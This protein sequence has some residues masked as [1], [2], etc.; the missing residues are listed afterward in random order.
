MSPQGDILWQKHFRDSI[1]AAPAMDQNGKVFLG[2]STAILYCCNLKGKNEWTIKLKA[3]I[4]A[5]PLVFKGIL[6]V[7]DQSGTCYAI[8]SKTRKVLWTHD[9]KTP[10]LSSPVFNIEK[11]SLIISLKDYRIVS[12]GLGGSFKWEF[13]AGGIILS[14]PAISRECDIYITSMDHY[15]Y[16]LSPLGKLKWKFK[17][18]R[19]IKSS[20]VIDENGNVYFGS[21]DGYFYCLTGNGKL[22]WRYRGKSAFNASPVID[23]N[24]HVYAGD[25]SGRFYAFDAQ[26]EVLW[27]F[28]IEDYV[29]NG[30]SIISPSNILITGACD[31]VVYGFKING[32]LSDTASWP[33]IL[34]NRRN[35]G[36]RD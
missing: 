26:G 4:R 21:Y 14:S 10:V 5:T 22:K 35:S 32:N 20:P 29:R 3:G 36:Y 7:I 11:K 34:G 13:K 18:G 15:L 2:T 6:Y 30:F 24:G 17:S 19:W 1:P 16:K 23:S 12:L 25:S 8:S 9:L 31:S 28:Q 27:N 33:K